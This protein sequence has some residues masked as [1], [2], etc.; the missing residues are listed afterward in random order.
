MDPLIIPYRSGRIAVL[1]D[2]HWDS[3]ARVGG[4]PIDAHELECYLTSGLDA[5]IIAGDFANGPPQAWQMALCEMKRRLTIDH[6]YIIPGNHDYY[7][8]GLDGDIVLA[9]CAQEAGVTFVQKRELRHGNT[10]FFCCTLWTDFELSGHAALSKRVAQR[11]LQDYQ[12][13]TKADPAQAPL[14]AGVV[15]PQRRVRITPDDTLAVHV[16]QRKWLEIGLGTPHF[17]GGAGHTAVVTHH[18]PHPGVAGEID[19][20][21]AAFHS[22]LSDMIQS[23]QPDVW[24]FGHSHRRLRARVGATDIRNVS[25]GY[26]REAFVS[27]STQLG[28]VCIWEGKTR[29]DQTRF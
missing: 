27:G 3:Y 20:L 14:S 17:S 24:F 6:V 15:E 4:N 23:Y 9:R 5:L 29:P 21:T 16:D 8:H 11:G 26:P 19:A 18:G 1:A 22:D 28:D 2:L 7:L 12:R 10:R 25:V 13:I